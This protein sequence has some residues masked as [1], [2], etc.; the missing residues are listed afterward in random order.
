M[1]FV[2]KIPDAA[3]NE[4]RRLRKENAKLRVR[5]KEAEAAIAKAF[6]HKCLECGDR[7]TDDGCTCESVSWEQRL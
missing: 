2:Y 4:I 5:A 7:I 1:E 3:A 6:P